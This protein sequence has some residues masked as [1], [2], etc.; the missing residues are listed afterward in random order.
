MKIP[1]GGPY[2]TASFT[3]YAQPSP[4]AGAGG[5]GGLHARTVNFASGV[6][7]YGFPAGFVNVVNP[8]T[9][10]VAGQYL[11]NLQTSLGA[12]NESDLYDAG[13]DGT[14]VYVGQI[15]EV[16]SAYEVG[17]LEA[18]TPPSGPFTTLTT[19]PFVATEPIVPSAAGGIV[20][21]ADYAIG[22]LGFSNPATGKARI[23]P[24]YN[25]NTGYFYNANGVAALADGTAWFT[26]Y[27]NTSPAAP[28]ETFIPTCIGHTIYTSTWGLWPGTSVAVFG[29]GANGAQVVG[30]MEAPSANSGPF[31]TSSN[32][33]AV[34]TVTA[35][36]A[37]NDHNF[38]ITGVAAGA[39]TVTV[40]DAH[41]ISQ[42]INVTVTTTTGTVQLRRRA[43]GVQP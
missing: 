8:S 2:T 43:G 39:C 36:T 10:A 3:V 22:G 16:F 21:Y 26:C 11:T 7:V 31:T 5:V 12:S 17:A 28:G 40:T 30:I 13:T 33:T 6:L 14:S 38:T 29:A 32:N 20:Y 25:A 23:F 35:P 4:P 19:V 41:S 15:G 1:S 18:F 27:G 42:A 9:G 37:S 24:T 34:C